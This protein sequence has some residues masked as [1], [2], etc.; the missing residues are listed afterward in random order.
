M[1]R[2]ASGFG[3]GSVVFYS[4]FAHSFVGAS[5]Y[6]FIHSILLC[7]RTDGLIAVQGYRLVGKNESTLIAW[8]LH[9]LPLATV[10]LTC[11]W[12]QGGVSCCQTERA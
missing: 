10:K 12:L 7:L 1:L 5:H 3:V 8:K 11:Q 6:G 2:A 4:A 9:S